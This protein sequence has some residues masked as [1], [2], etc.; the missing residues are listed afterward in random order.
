MNSPEPTKK[1]SLGYAELEAIRVLRKSMQRKPEI[2]TELL[3]GAS[4]EIAVNLLLQA[5]VEI[6]QLLEVSRAF[7]AAAA[8]LAK[9]EKEDEQA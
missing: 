5:K 1:L 7:V 9:K 4:R 8:E 6:A 2:A 3:K